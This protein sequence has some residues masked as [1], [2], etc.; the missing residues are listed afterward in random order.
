[1]TEQH[2]KHLQDKTYRDAQKKVRDLKKFY[3]ELISWAGTSIFLIGLNIFLSGNISWAKY[4]VFFWGLAL[5]FQ[6]IRLIKNHSFDRHWEEK[7]IRKMTDS[8]G[9]QSHDD[10]MVKDYSDELLRDHRERKKEPLS[11]YR[12]AGRPWKDEDLV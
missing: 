1:M 3:T 9:N 8:N 5:I 10:E 4:P 11:D 12:T 7:M 6:V 2:D